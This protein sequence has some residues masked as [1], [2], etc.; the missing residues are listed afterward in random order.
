MVT[1]G[2]R[3]LGSNG[4][5]EQFTLMHRTPHLESSYNSTEANGSVF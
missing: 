5:K 1:V 3:G 4:K 2:Q